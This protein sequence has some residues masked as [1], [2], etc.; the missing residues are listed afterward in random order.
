MSQI[1]DGSRDNPLTRKVE[2][3]EDRN[4]GKA[5]AASVLF[6]ELLP[7]ALRQKETE[8]AASELRH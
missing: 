1:L 3:R 6:R 2:F 5:Q 8:A 7:Q 4:V